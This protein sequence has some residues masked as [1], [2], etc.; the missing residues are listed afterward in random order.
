MHLVV[1]VDWCMLVPI[2]C[3]SLCV[4][5][6]ALCSAFYGSFRAADNDNR[7]KLK[8]IPGQNDYQHNYVN[9]SY[10]DVSQ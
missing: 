9:A 4:I 2:K 1:L 3:S 10:I 6:C 7:I 5:V 8:P